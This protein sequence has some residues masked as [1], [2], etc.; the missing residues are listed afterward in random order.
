MASERAGEAEAERAELGA[1]GGHNGHPRWLWQAI[2][3]H[4]GTGFAYVCGRRQEA[5]FLPRHALREPCGLTRFD[6]AYWGASP[7]QLAP[8][9]PGPGKRHTQKIEPKHLTLRTRMKR[10]ARKTLC[11][12]KSLQMHALVLG[13]FVNRDAFGQPV[14]KWPSPLWKH[15]PLT[16]QE[17]P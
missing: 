9:V 4:P 16:L 14:E 13:L 7:R 17:L 10:L 12:S 11:F 6:T 3:H 5:V 15:Y 8:E 1:G 2:D